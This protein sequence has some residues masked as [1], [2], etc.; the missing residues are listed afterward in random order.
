[1]L[2]GRLNKRQHHRLATIA[3]AI[4]VA[5]LLDLFFLIMPEFYRDRLSVHWL[6]VAAIAGV[7]GL[8]MTM[9]LWRLGSLPLLPPNDPEL[10]SALARKH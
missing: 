7:G 9:F 3:A 2:L 4:L 10:S 8:W 6:D 1:V 5:R